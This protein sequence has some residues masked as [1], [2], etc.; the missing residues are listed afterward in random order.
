MPATNRRLRPEFVYLFLNTA[1]F[2]ARKGKVERV[3]KGPALRWR[4]APSSPLQI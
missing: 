1:N 4:L 2:M 3:G